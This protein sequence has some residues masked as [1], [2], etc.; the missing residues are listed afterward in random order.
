MNKVKKGDRVPFFSLKDHEGNDFSIRPLIGSPM[1]IYFYPKDDTP[2][3]TREACSFR[4]KYEDFI[5]AGAAVIGISEDT[6]ES[7]HR[8]RERY[9][10]PFTLLSDPGNEVRKRFG[11]P[12]NLFGLIPGRVTYI[13]DADGMVRHVFNSQYMATRHVKEALRVIRKMT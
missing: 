7:H 12:A 6:P 4:D 3:C 8:F 5:K 11:V 13:V 1:V 9:N 2:G 10:L